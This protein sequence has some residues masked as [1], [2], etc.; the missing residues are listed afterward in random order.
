MRAKHVLILVVVELTLSGDHGQCQWGSTA[1]VL[2]LVVVELTLSAILNF[3]KSMPENK[4]NIPIHNKNLEFLNKE[5]LLPNFLF[6]T[7]II[8]SH[9]IC[10]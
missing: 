8:K 9:T 2:I 3:I 1:E 4:D 6:Y 7:Y 5:V 10:C